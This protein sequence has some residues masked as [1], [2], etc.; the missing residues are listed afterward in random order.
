MRGQSEGWIRITLSS[1]Q[2]NY[3]RKIDFPAYF[4]LKIVKNA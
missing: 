1:L 4:V 2:Q 3:V